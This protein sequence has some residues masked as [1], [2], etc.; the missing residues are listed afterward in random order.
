MKP[1]LL[2]LVLTATAPLSA[3]PPADLCPPLAE[4][5]RVAL[6]EAFRLGAAVDPLPG[7]HDAPSAVL[8]VA[9]D[10]EVLVRHPRPPDGFAL[11]VPFDSLLGGPVYVRDRQFQPDFLATFPVGGVPTVVVGTPGQTGLGPTDWVLTLLHEHVH[12]VQMAQPEYFDAVAALGLARGDT[13]GMW[14][15]TYPFPYD[16]PAVGERF[17]AYRTALADAL[18]DPTPAALAEVRTT[19]A[20]LRDRLGPADD[21]YLAFQLWQEGV[22]RYVEVRGAEAAAEAGGALPAFRALPGAVPYGVGAAGLR[23]QVANQL[24]GLELAGARRNV[25]YP[26]GAAEAL[27]L[28]TARPGWR[29]RYHAEPFDLSRYWVRR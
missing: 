11:A 15:L 21:R 22:A 8:L 27:L 25:V 10:R 3:Q 17:D 24:R 13:T 28:D 6:A 18:A 12:Q 16:E 29:H 5:D 9:G 20:A 26:V 7:W 4:A 23:E 14:M 1:V 19:R 2:A